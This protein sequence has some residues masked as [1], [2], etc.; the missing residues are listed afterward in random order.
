MVAA[1][2]PFPDGTLYPTPPPPK[3]KRKVK[4][5]DD[6]N[7]GNAGAIIETSVGRI[8]FNMILPEG[9]DFYNQSLRSGELASVISDCY[10]VLG[11][12]ETIDL[13]DDMKSLGFRES[14]RSGLSFATVLTL[15][16]V[17]VL[18]AVFYRV[19]SGPSPARQR[20]ES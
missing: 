2:A 19:D 3:P 14:T 17:P 11:R 1:M 12:R 5:K 9:M 18:Y 4:T 13:L 6:L 15:V 20:I 16:V 10:A 8:L 7:P